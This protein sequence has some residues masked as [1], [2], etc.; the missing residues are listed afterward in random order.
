M[1]NAGFVDMVVKV[2]LIV[3]GLN[4]GLYGVFNMDLVAMIFGTIP[5][6][7]TVVYALVGVAAVYSAYCLFTGCGCGTS[8]SSSD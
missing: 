8:S 6:L 5:M 7:A 3:G 2:L 1:M 4:W